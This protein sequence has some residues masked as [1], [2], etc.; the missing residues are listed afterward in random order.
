MNSTAVEQALQS[1][2]IALTEDGTITANSSVSFS[3]N[4]YDKGF[5]WAGSDYT[6]KFVMVADEDRLFSSETIDIA[7]NKHLAINGNKVLTKTNLAE[8][9]LKV[10]YVK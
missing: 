8:V 2:T 5:Y 1:L 10:T 6:K 9:Y 3:G 4:I 7:R